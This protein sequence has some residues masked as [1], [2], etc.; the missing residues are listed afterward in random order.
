MVIE[1]P[2]RPTIF[3]GESELEARTARHT[4]QHH[5]LRPRGDGRWESVHELA[6]R[7]LAVEADGVARVTVEAPAYPLRR[8]GA[9]ACSDETLTDIWATSA[10][11]LRQF[12]H[13]LLLDGIKRD[14][15]PWMGDLAV[16]VPAAAYAFPDRALA[17]RG[18]IALGQPV[19]GYVNGIVD[20]SLWWLI[21]LADYA[22]YFDGA[23]FLATVA[24]D[25]DAAL[26]TLAEEADDDGV[27][28]PRPGVDAYP[29]AVFVDWGF[30]VEPGRDPVAL[31]ALWFWAL[32]SGRELLERA[33]HDGAVRW[34]Q[35][36]DRL[37][38]TLHAR[39]W[40]SSA[41]GWRE[42][43]DGDVAASPYPGIF[44]LLAGLTPEGAVAGQAARQLAAPETR[45]PF[46]TTF[47]VRALAEAGRPDA[48]VEQ[49]RR[50]WGEMLALGATTFWEEFPE[51][52]ASPY[53][54]YGRPFGKS[55]CHAWA[56]GPAQL[57]P[58][59]V[60]GLRPLSD[61]W[62][63]FAVDPRLGDLAWAM[64]IV[65]VPGG[66]ITVLATQAEVSV[67]VPAGHALVHGGELLQG[68]TEL[69][70]ATAP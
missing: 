46:V 59:I 36:A 63:T 51:D 52:G 45:T 25:V 3:A 37:R 61:G 65:A 28:R 50:R 34:G 27:L 32:R 33:G 13:G 9:F 23:D 64:A 24:D 18:F 14:R 47:A 11:T 8:R 29:K 7:Y 16:S 69:R 42:Y 55:L 31:Q 60:C 56:A 43:L 44:A 35:A 54:M 49:V 22:R 41:G 20:Y 66:E 40:D 70:F 15:V 2:G 17:E 1:C 68:P 5:D 21:C 10:H 38:A 67:T 58:E 19:S 6:L 62:A 53:E 57:L 30:D 4:E 12:T 26:A 48:A 39:A